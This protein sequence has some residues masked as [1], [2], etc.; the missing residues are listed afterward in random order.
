MH[1]GEGVRRALTHVLSRSEVAG[2]DPGLGAVLGEA[3]VGYNVE[4]TTSRYCQLAAR[5]MEF[6]A[7]RRL[8][9]WPATHLTVCAWIL[10]LMTSVQPSSLKMYLA[11]VRF[12]HVSN[13][14]GEW[15]LTATQCDF[16]RRVLRYVKRRFPCST[17]ASKVPISLAMLR[18]ILSLLPGWP[19]YEQM[20]YDDL[21]FACA[22]VVGVHGFL[23]GGEFLYKPKQ[24]RPILRAARMRVQFVQGGL[25]LTVRVPQPKTQ[26]FQS[27]VSVPVFASA[28]DGDPFCPVRLWRALC[29]RSPFAD[30][31]VGPSLPAFHNR[32][33][34]PLLVT[35]MSARTTT[36]LSAAGVR[37]IDG[38]G[39][40]V[41]VK[42]ASWRAGGVRSAVDAGM[43]EALIMDLG[44][45]KS[46][47]W[48]HYLLH[49]THDIRA[50]S[51]RMVAHASNAAPITDTIRVVR[52]V[53]P[54]AQSVA[55]DDQAAHTVQLLFPR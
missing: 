55:R 40:A 6:C 14:H 33:G 22:S 27:E 7:L 49:T 15:V 16:V 47:A 34:S 1:R 21:L 8:R 9:P 43:P 53:L 28:A 45:W 18:R 31:S 30:K 4:G 39:N 11:A 38:R 50:A 36:L 46:Y 5:Y 29:Q 24:D 13:G 3:L 26:W 41:K 48:M 51:A 10:R 52:E 17:K 32:D 2:C 35:T 44:R 23:R 42:A 54:G 37:M 25:A 19:A 12:A 20:A